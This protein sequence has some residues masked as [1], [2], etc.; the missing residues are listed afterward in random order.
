MTGVHLPLSLNLSGVGR[1]AASWRA[2]AS[3]PEDALE[4]DHYVN[5]AQV[6]ERGGF[7]AVFLADGPIQGAEPGSIPHRFEPFELLAAIAAA[8]D[9]IGLIGTFSTS[10]NDP[11][12]V[13]ERANSLNEL[14]AGRAAVNAV[15]SA[16]DRV[17]QNFG[18][19]RQQDHSTRYARVDEFLRLLRAVW[20]GDDPGPHSFFA[21][22]DGRRVPTPRGGPVIVQAGSSAEGQEVAA[23]HADV[24][25]AASSTLANGRVFRESVRARAVA[26]G[27]D[28][29]S[30]K[31]LPGLVPFVA[32]SEREARELQRELD[33]LHEEGVDVIAQLGGV[34]GLD[35]SG[36]DPEGPLPPEESDDDRD[37]AGGVS[38]AG[39]VR[40]IAAEER[41]S[42]R[43][44]AR[45]LHNGGSGNIQWKAVGTPEQVADE[46][47]SWYRAGAADGF[48]LMVPVQPSGLE[49]FV[50]EVVPILERRGYHRSA[51]GPSTL[52]RNLRLEEGR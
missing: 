4:I 24:V 40:A 35:L 3:R 48:N 30:V 52:R 22:Y 46:L 16:G 15:A 19:E 36:V 43:D 38:M 49:V 34:L 28:P 44:L 41:L 17:A 7:D 50:D 31:V 6:A 33:S 51:D 29:D 39:V 5:V 8:T 11:Y 12:L 13:A 26:R 21:P 18:Q 1:H 23:A 42:V 10:Y 2:P 20:H 37:H 14:S 32:A 9:R 25:Y 47:E 27:R 45:R